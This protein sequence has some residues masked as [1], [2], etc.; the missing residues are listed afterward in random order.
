[1][2]K[3]ETVNQLNEEITLLDE[4]INNLFARKKI[5][6]ITN[7][8]FSSKLRDLQEKATVKENRILHIQLFG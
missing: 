4:Q 5:D 6:R 1:M 3:Q 7:I 2:N 8:D